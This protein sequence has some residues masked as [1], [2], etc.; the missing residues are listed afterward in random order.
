MDN[1][2]FS[3]TMS[4]Y[5]R[6]DPRFFD[7]ALK[8]VVGQTLPPTQIVLVVDGPIPDELQKVIDGYKEKLA[9]TE[10]EFKVVYLAEN[11]GLGN[12]R[13]VS[14]E[15]C[16]CEYIAVMDADDISAADR[17]E[18]QVGY[19]ESHPEAAVVGG[20]IREFISA[21]DP[22]DTS[23]TAGVR[24]VPETNEQIRAYMRRRCPL[25]HVTVMFRHSAVK[26]A[27][28]YLDW[29]CNEDYYLWIRMALKGCVF[30]N[31]PDTLVNVRVGRDMYERRGGV[32]Y[33]RSEEGI[34][35]LMLKNGLIGLP[36]YLYNCA[37]RLVVQVLLPNKVRGWLYRRFARE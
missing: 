8:S 4:V 20:Q 31:L 36:D 2:R 9:P 33:F 7:C 34:Q 22:E 25:N 12:A 23:N 27:G 10:T 3:V 26:A 37:V 17:F 21:D 32:R 18:K 13:R 28:D 24:I 1:R 14:L 15:N 35:R 11:R 5:G 16:S 29:Y 30:S 6:D 19:L